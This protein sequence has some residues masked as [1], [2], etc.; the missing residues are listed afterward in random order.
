MDAAPGDD[1]D[2]QQPPRTRTAPP[3][4]SQ[5]L[6]LAQ[7]Q[8]TAPDPL[9]PDEAALDP[10][11]PITLRIYRD[12]MGDLDD[13]SSSGPPSPS[14]RAM[15]FED[16]KQA[17]PRAE[18]EETRHQVIEQSLEKPSSRRLSVGPEGGAGTSRTGS[19]GSRGGSSSLFNWFEPWKTGST[20]SFE[21]YKKKK[22]DGKKDGDGE[23]E[24]EEEGSGGVDAAAE[25]AARGEW[26]APDKKGKKGVD[27]RDDKDD[28]DNE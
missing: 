9:L 2:L 18:L 4:S 5:P 23:E 28:K 20:M 12:E 6:T 19:L 3:S 26:D 11:E 16:Y 22:Q 1:D 15:T 14:Q 17:V 24:V 25:A 13:A 27:D 21:D 7:Y 8:S 10:N